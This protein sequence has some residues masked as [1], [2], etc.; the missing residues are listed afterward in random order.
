MTIPFVGGSYELNVRKA[1]VQRAVNLFPVM[2]EVPGG[3]S[4]AY[5][6]SIPGLM[7]FSVDTKVTGAILLESG[8]YL[9]QESG[10][11]LLLE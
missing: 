10:G 9:L 2:N 1:D 5:L 3:K 11:K 8:F 7:A 4:I 6:D